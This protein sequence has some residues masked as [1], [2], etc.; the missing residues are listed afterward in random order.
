MV[1]KEWNVFVERYSCCYEYV[2][3]HRDS[4]LLI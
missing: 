2:F 3:V 4:G 1:M